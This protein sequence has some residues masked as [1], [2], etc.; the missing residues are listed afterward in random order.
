MMNFSSSEAD[1][2]SLHPSVPASL[3]NC[4]PPVKRF[5]QSGSSLNVKPLGIMATNLPYWESREDSA[6]ALK[7]KTR[8]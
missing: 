1:H 4:V 5:V 8:Y 2:Q 3:S 7:L 6:A